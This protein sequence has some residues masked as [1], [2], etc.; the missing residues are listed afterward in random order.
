MGYDDG[1]L[2]DN[3]RIDLTTIHQDAHGLAESSVELAVDLLTEVH[4]L[5]AGAVLEPTLK[6]RGTT[7]PPTR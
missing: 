5:D 2:S 1:R 3:P 4:A 6:V 7:A